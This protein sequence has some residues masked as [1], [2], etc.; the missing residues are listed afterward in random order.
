VFNRD[1]HFTLTLRNSVVKCGYSVTCSHNIEETHEAFKKTNYDL[2]FID[3]RRNASNPSSGKQAAALNVS[4]SHHQSSSGGG[5]PGLNN[6]YD[7]ENICR[8]IRNLYHYT[9]IV[10]L[11]PN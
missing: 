7:Y 3:C 4:S 1:D 6:H 8:F 5:L 10:A 11:T 9:V 2:V